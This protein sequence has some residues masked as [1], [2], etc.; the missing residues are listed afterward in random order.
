MRLKSPR[1]LSLLLLTPAGADDT[2]ININTDTSPFYK[3]L[4]D[5]VNPIVLDS[6]NAHEVAA[7]AIAKRQSNC[8]DGFNSCALLGAAEACCQPNAVC[9]RDDANI[10]ACCPSGAACTGH[11]S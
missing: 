6:H 4:F 1:L 10:I 5:N 7:I 2:N 9:S 11:L 8:P 3:P